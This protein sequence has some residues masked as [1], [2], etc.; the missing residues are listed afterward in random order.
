MVTGLGDVQAWINHGRFLHYFLQ[1]LSYLISK[2]NKV[3]GIKK[4]LISQFGGLLVACNAIG[5]ICKIS[6]MIHFFLNF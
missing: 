1:N 4:F 2:A 3:E 5:T 6:E